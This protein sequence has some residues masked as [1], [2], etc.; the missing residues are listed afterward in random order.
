MKIFRRIA[1][2]TMIAILTLSMTG[3]HADSAR[4]AT[5]KDS[6]QHL[7]TI[8]ENLLQEEKAS[9]DDE[10]TKLKLDGAVM[11]EP[12]DGYYA[13]TL[14][15]ISVLFTDGGHLDIGIIALNVMPTDDPLQWKMTLALPSPITF[16]GKESKDTLSMTVGKQFFAGVWHEKFE[17]FTKLK[18]RYTNVNIQS[19]DRT[20]SI[21]IPDITA[22]Y[23]LAENA[24][25][26]WTGPMQIVLSG[27][28][29]SMPDGGKAHIGK[30]TGISTL[31]D[32]SV[33]TATAYNDSLRALDESYKAGEDSVSAQHVT[34]MYN[35]V[36]GFIS[37]VWDGFTMKV[38]ANDI[39]LTR[40]PI[41]GSPAG[42][43]KLSNAGFAFDMLGFRK[44]SVTLR[45][46]M[47]YAGLSLKPLSADFDA[48]TPT[49]MNIDISINKLPF[50]EITALGKTSLESV[51]QLP[52][53]MAKLAG[54]QALFSLP[55]LFTKAGTTLDVKDTIMEGRDYRF[56]MNGSL[57]PD[58]SALKGAVGKGRLEVMGLEKI[59]ALLNEQ[60]K[61]PDI[62]EESKSKLQSTLS[63]LS[64][65]QLAGQQGKDALGNAVRLYDFE[66]NK[67]GQI[68]LNGTDMTL[69]MPKDEKPT[70]TTTNETGQKPTPAP[71]PA[72]APAPAKK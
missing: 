13:V 30:V 7:K 25:H 45:L 47:N 16:H 23:D 11:V 43:L 53:E 66:L 15:H 38:E 59:T 55:Q 50:G 6:A 21:L 70:P 57:S 31:F 18:S 32:Y 36:A 2:I 65:L 63:T 33:E 4:A 10:T 34:G 12:A 49:H 67:Q 40:P 52:P 3:I 72:P 60:L 8:F 46:G 35:M 27:L 42:E 71:T 19:Q 68:L 48:T 51:A 5:N 17:N 62:S 61:K 9:V 24:N 54:L 1:I 69:L 44:D 26:L 28:Q 29:V 41:P 22:D 37:K 39:L 20:F 64:I 58:M 14:P 56:S